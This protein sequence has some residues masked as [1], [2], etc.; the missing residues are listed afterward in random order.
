MTPLGKM[1]KKVVLVGLIVLLAMW[2][3]PPW[4]HGAGAYRKTA[5]YYF[6]FDTIQRSH[7]VHTIDFGRLFAQSVAVCIIIVVLALLTHPK[8][9]K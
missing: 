4:I 2:L 6:L 3:Y 5:G 8:E 1:Q 9:Q 7:S